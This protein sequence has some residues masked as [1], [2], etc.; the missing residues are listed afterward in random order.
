MN[1][2][3]LLPVPDAALDPVTSEPRFGSYRGGLPSVDLRGMGG[4]ALHRVKRAKRWM[5]FAAASD[6][7]YVALAIVRLG[8]AAN[9]F[10]YVL[11]RK[12]MRM[13]VSRSAI[14]PTLA[15]RVGDR[16][17][18]GC[19]A[20][21]DFRG[22]H[23]RVS[24]AVGSSRYDVAARFK[25]LEIDATFDT[26]GAPPALTAIAPIAP[27]MVNTTE[28]RALLTVGGTCTVNGRRISLDG[29]LGGYDYTNGLLAR[30]TAWRWAWLL[31][32]AT[33]GERVGMNLVQGFVGEPECGVWIDGEVYP[34]AE[35]RFDFARDRPLDPW[36]VTTADGGV[37]L[38]FEPGGMHSE[39][40]NLGIVASR[41]VQPA[42][43]YS[44]TIRVQGGRELTL[45]GVLGVTEDQDSLW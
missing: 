7:V 4:G 24:R 23:A 2:R 29:A 5:Y 20:Q 27:D 12:T 34:L 3:T 11:D 32:R 26:Q 13:V 30:R 6:E 1:M 31:G 37:D 42:G 19:S 35:G 22:A 39:N 18:E 43:L 16:A 40:T 45:E 17:G 33:T 41:F 21:F 15:C 44:G 8:Y 9:A 38:R 25:D 28:K 14:G 36:R 10:T